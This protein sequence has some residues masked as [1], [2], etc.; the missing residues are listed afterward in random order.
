MAKTDSTPALTGALIKARDSAARRAAHEIEALTSMLRRET[1]S[2]ENPDAELIVAGTLMRIEALG[3]AISALLG[4]GRE[5]P[6]DIAEHYELVFGKP[7][8]VVNV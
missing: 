1:A 5:R 7:L 8:E 2:G 6:V 4:Y 3:G